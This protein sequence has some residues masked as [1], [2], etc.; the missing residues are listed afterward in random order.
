[1]VRGDRPPQQAF[2]SLLQCKDQGTEASGHSLGPRA[3]ERVAAP[4]SARMP[5]ALKLA[6]AEKHMG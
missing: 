1:V 6:V 4:A 2:N 5:A 3:L